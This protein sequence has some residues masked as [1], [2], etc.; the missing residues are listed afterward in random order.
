MNAGR[1]SSIYIITG[2]MLLVAG[3]PLRNTCLGFYVA[4][5]SIILLG[6]G[7]L[8]HVAGIAGRQS[9]ARMALAYIT[10]GLIATLS[11]LFIPASYRDVGIMLSF[12]LVEVGMLFAVA[13]MVARLYSVVR[14]S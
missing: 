4:S 6:V 10:L 1:L 13:Y 9:T 2:L 3:I 12:A 11:L 5:A 8:F 7:M 14:R